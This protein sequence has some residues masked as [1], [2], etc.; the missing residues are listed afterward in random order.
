[1]LLFLIQ[2]ALIPATGRKNY[3][4]RIRARQNRITLGLNN[5][6]IGS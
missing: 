2:Y 5:D 4:K 1:M 3:R 6:K